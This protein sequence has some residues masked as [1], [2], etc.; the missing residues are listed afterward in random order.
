MD[1]AGEDQNPVPGGA[2]QPASPRGVTTGEERSAGR[3]VEDSLRKNLAE[4]N[5]T[6]PIEQDTPLGPTGLD[7]D[8]LTRAFLWVEVSTD[9]GVTLPEDELV[10]LPELTFGELV[11]LVEHRIRAAGGG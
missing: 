5:F 2:E 8:S 10:R 9:Y 3:T 11:A 4:M 1:E 7:I 6:A